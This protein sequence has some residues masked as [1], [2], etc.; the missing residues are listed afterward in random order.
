MQQEQ[1]EITTEAKSSGGMSMSYLKV[2][3]V[4]LVGVLCLVGFV[5]QL[6]GIGDRHAACNDIVGFSRSDC[7][8]LFR[9]N[10]WS[11]FFQIIIV[12]IL[13]L[14]TLAKKLPETRHAM[15][16]FL[17][18]STVQLILSANAFLGTDP[19]NGGII[20]AGKTAGE[21]TAAAGFVLSAIANFLLILGVGVPEIPLTSIPQ[22]VFIR[23]QNLVG[24]T[25]GV[26]TAAIPMSS[27]PTA[28]TAFHEPAIISVAT[29]A[30]T[31]Q[32]QTQEE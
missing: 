9:F 29:D 5:L 16:S 17:T 6:G 28:G 8:D 22:T 23:S 13:G 32:V 24:Q 7:R 27:I 19:T 11:A 30:E 21:R 26:S 15:L 14:M 4:V 3:P 20:A 10:W 1:Q 12:C 2:I 31:K 25:R 18:I